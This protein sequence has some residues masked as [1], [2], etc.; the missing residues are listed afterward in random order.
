MT[1][2]GTGAAPGIAQGARRYF[3]S[4]PALPPSWCMNSFLVRGARLTF[5]TWETSSPHFVINFPFFVLLKYNGAFKSVFYDILH[6]HR[7]RSD[8]EKTL[9]SDYSD[10]IVHI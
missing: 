2:S 7:P 6:V 10:L 4:T 1:C 5:K 3:R 8:R 9:C